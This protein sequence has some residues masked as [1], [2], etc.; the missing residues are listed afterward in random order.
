MKEYIPAYKEVFD[1]LTPDQKKKIEFISGFLRSD[2][3]GT[4]QDKFDRFSFRKEFILPEK[5]ESIVTEETIR[6][7]KE[8]T[9]TKLDIDWRELRKEIQAIREDIKKDH[10]KRISQF[11]GF[12]IDEN[13]DI[14]NVLFNAL[15]TNNLL[16][17]YSNIKIDSTFLSGP[18]DTHTISK[19]ES[20]SKFL[21]TSLPEYESISNFMADFV[22]LVI[23]MRQL[24]DAS[25]KDPQL[26]NRF[27]PL[28]E[29]FKDPDYFKRVM[30]DPR[31]SRL[32]TKS[33]DRYQLRK[34]K[35]CYLGGLAHVLLNEGRLID[36]IRTYQDCA[37]VFCPFFN[38]KFHPVEEKSFQSDRAKDFL[39]IKLI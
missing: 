17:A 9:E 16:Y 8:L 1:N 23:R 36:S 11:E 32:F 2:V 34:G 35:K 26:T 10:E 38:V 21:A 4:V 18:M 22:Y 6:A 29:C 24:S 31:V 13:G 12:P 14:F 15:H 7:S 33:G 27:P 25:Y 28:P 5:T 37:R 30:A 19:Y 39:F 3:M 20:F